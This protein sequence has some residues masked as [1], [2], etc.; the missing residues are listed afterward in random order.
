MTAEC[1]SQVLR[2]TDA[3]TLIEVRFASAA[4]ID[5]KCTWSIGAESLRPSGLLTEIVDSIRKV[6]KITT[7]DCTFGIQA[8]SPEARANLR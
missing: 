8:A 3:G 1:D 5:E 4:T 2:I 7:L 6:F